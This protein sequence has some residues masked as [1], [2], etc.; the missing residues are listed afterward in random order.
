MGV[1]SVC[2][3]VNAVGITHVKGIPGDKDQENGPETI[4]D[5]IIV[6]FSHSNVRGQTWRK[7]EG[8]PSQTADNLCHIDFTLQ[9]TK[10]EGNHP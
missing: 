6:T 9:Q 4:L 5:V 3:G 7:D 10:D 2:G 1:S 8:M